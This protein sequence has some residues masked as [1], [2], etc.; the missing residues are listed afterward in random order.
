MPSVFTGSP[1]S[2]LRRKLL[3]RGS[4]VANAEN[5]LVFSAFFLIFPVISTL[6]RCEAQLL[7]PCDRSP[8]GRRGRN[9]RN[10]TAPGAAGTQAEHIQLI[11][12]PWAWFL[13]LLPG[14]YRILRQECLPRWRKHSHSRT[15][16][17]ALTTH[18]APTIFGDCIKEWSMCIWLQLKFSKSH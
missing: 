4:Q 11:M 14:Q 6:A 10:C 12:A 5:Q 9:C 1:G 17:H 3:Y 13:L 18:L 15:W 8:V 2:V 7:P 16:T